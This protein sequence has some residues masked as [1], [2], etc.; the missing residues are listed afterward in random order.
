ML[1]I[2]LD[3]ENMSVNKI[4]KISTLMQLILWFGKE[5]VNI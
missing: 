1:E 2:V 4:I 3:T 5:L